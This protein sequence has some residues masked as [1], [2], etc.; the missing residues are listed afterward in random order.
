MKRAVACVFA[1]VFWMLLLCTAFSFRIKEWMTPKV[2]TTMASSDQETFE[3][4]LPINC[5]YRDETGDHLYQPAEASVAN[6][7]TGLREVLTDNYQV[8]PDHLVMKWGGMERYIQ[9][10]SRQLKPE[11]TVR[12]LQWPESKEDD[13]WLAVFPEEVPVVKGASNRLTVDTQAGNAFLFSVSLAERPYSESRAKSMISVTSPD[14]D[15][16]DPFG[17]ALYAQNLEYHVYSLLDFRQFFAQTP[18]L[19]LLLALMLVSL[20]LWAASCVQARRGKKGRKWILCNAGVSLLL[21]VGIFL[22]LRRIDLPSSLLPVQTILDAHYYT[23]EFSLIF[24]GL[25]TLSANEPAAVALS[26][27]Q[28]ALWVSL[29]IL[30]AGALLGVGIVLL[31]SFKRKAQNKAVPRHAAVKSK[32]RED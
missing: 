19:S 15:E 31:E 30:V 26:Q 13:V 32:T 21:F 8:F 14:A 20:G 10:S 27:A 9:F 6:P 23:A 11:D 12:V 28:T 24:R 25:E 4:S 7:V 5:L 29:G 1:L 2:T 16:D 17:A 18:W 22:C 3:S